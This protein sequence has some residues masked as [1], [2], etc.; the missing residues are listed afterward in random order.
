M[1]SWGWP[2]QLQPDMG[3]LHRPNGGPGGV[4]G[5]MGLST[6]GGFP[7][8][9]HHSRRPSGCWVSRYGVTLTAGSV[10]SAMHFG[11]LCGAAW[12]FAEAGTGFQPA[13]CWLS[14]L[15]PMK[16]ASLL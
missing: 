2:S 10:Y 3:C 8:T 16:A 6:R 14:M 11:Q 15:E 13:Q 12:M 5:L 1:G 7:A 4:W 9:Q